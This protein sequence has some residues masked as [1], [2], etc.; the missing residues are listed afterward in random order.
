MDENMRKVFFVII[1]VLALN[2][3]YTTPASTVAP[4]VDFSKYIFAAIGTDATGNSVILT[5]AQMKVQNAL[6]SCGYNVI[7][8]TRI[9]ALDYEDRLQL[10]IVEFSI[11]SNSDESICII[12]FTDY[13]SGNLIATFRG[14]FGL[15]FNRAG[16]QRGAVDSAIKQMINT[17]QNKNI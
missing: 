6:V 11:S 12:Y 7:V 1:S 2:S 9:K 15:S 5:D 14:S 3:C 8:D 4:N 13:L 16:D 17:L 10:F